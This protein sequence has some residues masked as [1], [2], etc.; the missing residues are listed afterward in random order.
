MDDPI[1]FVAFPEEVITISLIPALQQDGGHYLVN[2]K[3]VRG[4]IAHR[5]NASTLRA[6]ERNCSFQ[7]NDACATV[8]VHTTGLFMVDACCGSNFDFPNGNPMGGPAFRPLR[9]YRT[10]L[11]GSTLTITDEVIN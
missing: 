8:D 5:V 7:P 11:S 4:I 2:N 6:F 10:Q 3:G 1:P 9:Q